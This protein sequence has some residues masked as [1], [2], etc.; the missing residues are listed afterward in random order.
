M[1]LDELKKTRW[2]KRWVRECGCPPD[3]DRVKIAL[4][5]NSVFRITPIKHAAYYAQ[6]WTILHKNLEMEA[7]F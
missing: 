7:F 1:T 5:P 4:N 2:W 3:Q 6:H